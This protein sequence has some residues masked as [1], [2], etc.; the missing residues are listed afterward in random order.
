MP[1]HAPRYVCTVGDAVVDVIVE[2]SRLPVVDDDVPAR[3]SITGG[4]QA[5]SVAAWCAALGARAAVVTRVGLDTAGALARSMLEQRGVAVLGPPVAGPTGTIMSIVTPDGKR[6]MASDRGASAG[7]AR[8]DL[9]EAWLVGCDWLHVSGYSLFGDDGGEAALSLASMAHDAGAE[10]SVDLSAA[11]VVTSLGA[12]EARRRVRVAGPGVVF[13]NEA[14]MA[15]IGSLEAPVVVV[16]AGAAG[17]R[18]LDAGGSTAFGVP[19]GTVVRDTTGAGD[20]FAAG[21]M[22]GGLRLALRAAQVCVAEPGAM[23]PSPMPR[24]DDLEPAE[25]V[26]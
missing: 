4:G 8:T 7:L 3:I 17:C 14:E 26:G 20:A 10:V 19:A 9:D 25:P 23:P 18:V 16:K 22:L 6:S 15:A 13:A 5:A 21:W 24:L 2:L 1:A 12:A 11:T